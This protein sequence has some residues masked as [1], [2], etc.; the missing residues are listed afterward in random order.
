MGSEKQPVD[1]YVDMKNSS[2]VSFHISNE[3]NKNY[4]DIKN[5][6]PIYGNCPVANEPMEIVPMIQL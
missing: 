4:D 1:T 2:E 3:V 5:V 6:R